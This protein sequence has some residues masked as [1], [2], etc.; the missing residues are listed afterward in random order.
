VVG[1]LKGAFFGDAY[2]LAAAL[3]FFMAVM[4]FFGSY[5]LVGELAAVTVLWLC[6]LASTAFNG[7]C[8]R[9]HASYE[10]VLIVGS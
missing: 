1:R 5:I 10:H 2:P 4:L 8:L 7:Y 9:L 6:V 3:W